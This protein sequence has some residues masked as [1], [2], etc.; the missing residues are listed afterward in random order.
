MPVTLDCAKMTTREINTS[1]RKLAAE[2]ETEIH[3]INPEAR[4]NLGVALFYPVKVVVEG[5]AGY[6][7]GGMNDGATFH[8]LGNTGWSVGEC[9]MS[10]EIVVE[11]NSA[12]STGASIRGGT[13]VVKGHAGARTGIAQKGGLIVI[14]G[15]TGYMTGFMMQ[16]GTM[17]ICGNAAEGLGDSMYAGTIYLGGEANQLGNDAVIKEMSNEDWRFLE[18]TLARYGLS[19]RR[20]LSEFKKI[21]SGGRLHNFSKADFELW[22][23][24][25]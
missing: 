21:G 19:G 24:A 5:T 25:M 3:L 8:I 1:L 9:M 23:V 12:S 14:G 10:G 7:C 20:P 22:R 13:V 18:E 15:D 2:G 11:K 16:R 4:H 6:Y 17:I